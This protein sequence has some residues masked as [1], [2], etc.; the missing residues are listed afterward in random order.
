MILKS[1]RMSMISIKRNETL[2]IH[3]LAGRNSTGDT[4]DTLGD[5]QADLLCGRWRLIQDDCA[6]WTM[7]AGRYE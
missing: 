3:E 2:N 1:P 5:T 4:G 6:E 7:V